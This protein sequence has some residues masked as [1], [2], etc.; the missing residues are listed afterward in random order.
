MVAGLV[1]LLTVSLY[2]R[3]VRTTAE[4]RAAVLEDSVETVVLAPGYYTSPDLATTRLM[5]IQRSVLIRAEV[6]GTVILSGWAQGQEA[7]WNEGNRLVEIRDADAV[8]LEGLIIQDGRGEMG[9]CISAKGVR[10]LKL[11][12]CTVRG[13]IGGARGHKRMLSGPALYVSGPDSQGWDGLPTDDNNVRLWEQDVAT[14]ARTVILINTTFYRNYGFLKASSYQTIQGGALFVNAFLEAYGTRFIENFIGDCKGD[15]GAV[16]VGMPL[17]MENCLVD[18]NVAS[19]NSGGIFAAHNA[20]I[21]NTVFRNN[22]AGGQRDVYACTWET[23]CAM[24]TEGDGI[25][26]TAGGCAARPKSCATHHVDP[27]SRSPTQ[28][29]GEWSSRADGILV[30]R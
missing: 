21:I 10:E 17:V 5:T 25:G 12:N 9:G 24:P 29:D 2:E 20:T 8:H 15:A 4:L 3:R 19:R 23:G 11:V 14:R 27:S 30:H 6:P 28:D 16:W 13:C 22:I 7:A 18:S 26:G 1:V